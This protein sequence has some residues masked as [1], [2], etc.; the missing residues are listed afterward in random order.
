MAKKITVHCF[1]FF[2][3]LL[4]TALPLSAISQ[5]DIQVQGL[6]KDKAVL[7]VNGNMRLLSVGQESPEG[8]KLLSADT[9]KALLSFE[10]K[11]FEL[12]L[13]SRISSAFKTAEVNE[14]RL[15]PDA[16]GHY[17][18]QMKINGRSVRVLLDT[19]A[20]TIAMNSN[21][22]KELGINYKDAPQGRVSTAAGV[23][24]SHKV[25][26]SSVQLGTITMNNVSAS[27]LEGDAPD[28]ILLGNSFLSRVDMRNEGSLMVLTAPF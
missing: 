26:L 14:V 19:G 23:V 27:V 15:T 6:F 18:T 3:C 28:I 5:P 24:N 21:Q 13:S 12:D 25:Q 7:N 4:S 10:G 1:I 2:V 16:R 8:L 11:E 17:I 20:T 22:A 9:S